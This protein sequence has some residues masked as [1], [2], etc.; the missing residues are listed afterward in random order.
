MFKAGPVVC[1]SPVKSS[2]KLVSTAHSRSE[3]HTDATTFDITLFML[4]DTTYMYDR[5]ACG[6]HNVS[7]SLECEIQP[8]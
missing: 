7:L 8:V 3:Q 4:A 1:P 6:K 2:V 5:I